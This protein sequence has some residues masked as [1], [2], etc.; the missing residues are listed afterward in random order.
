MGES[1]IWLNATD[2]SAVRLRCGHCESEAVFKATDHTGP[3]AE[4]RCPNCSMMMAGASQLIVAYRTFMG[5]VAR[6]KRGARFLAT[7]SH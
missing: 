3:S 7:V 6:Q 4:I 1:E 2:L 5:E